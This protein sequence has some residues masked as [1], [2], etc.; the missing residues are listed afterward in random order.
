MPLQQHPTHKA[1]NHSIGLSNLAQASILGDSVD[2]VAGGAAATN[3]NGR[4]LN[5]MAAMDDD[6]GLNT[7]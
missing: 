6:L 3:G 2:A 7:L 4:L 1:N 5:S